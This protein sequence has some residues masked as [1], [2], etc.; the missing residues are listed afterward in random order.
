MLHG[1]KPT[2]VLPLGRSCGEGV[3]ETD[4]SVAGLRVS[5][6]SGGKGKTYRTTSVRVEIESR[7]MKIKGQA[8]AVGRTRGGGKCDLTLAT[9]PINHHRHFDHRACGIPETVY[10]NGVNVQSGSS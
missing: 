6:R 2:L 5:G 10:V 9:S 7:Y 3:E 1:F 4:E 8:P